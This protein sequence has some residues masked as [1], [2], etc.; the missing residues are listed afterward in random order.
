[1]RG[2]RVSEVEI[3]RAHEDGGLPG[4]PGESHRTGAR[5]VVVSGPGVDVGAL[6]IE[7]VV[8]APGHG[9]RR[10]GRRVD[11][12][13]VFVVAGLPPVSRVLGK[14]P[15]HQR[16]PFQGYSGQALGDDRPRRSPRY[17][18]YL[19]AEHL[20]YFQGLGGQLNVDREVGSVGGDGSD[21]PGYLRE[22]RSSRREAGRGGYSHEGGVIPEADVVV[23]RR[24]ARQGNHHRH[25]LLEDVRMRRV[26][27]RGAE[28]RGGAGGGK[29]DVG[30]RQQGQGGGGDGA[31]ADGLERGDALVDERLQLESF[32]AR[33]PV[34]IE[35]EVLRIGVN[36]R[37]YRL[38]DGRVGGAPLQGALGLHPHQ[39]VKID[40]QLGFRRRGGSQPRPKRPGVV[41]GEAVPHPHYPFAEVGRGKVV[42][43]G[44][45][46]GE[47]GQVSGQ[48]QLEGG[49]VLPGYLLYHRGVVHDQL[50][51]PGFSGAHPP[52]R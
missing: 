52:P 3:R 34:R 23:H 45:V 48:A 15:G 38:Y 46:V 17:L 20:G 32:R 1:M 12:K 41:L 25:G 35:A 8:G 2:F 27:T 18:V 40:T 33:R 30:H 50:D 14:Y 39:R 43:A 44:G 37:R 9:Y 10:G 29:V 28:R 47:G 49:D 19:E 13:R 11:V 5:G 21:G 4:A 36:P 51:E 24:G 16:P 31:N 6:R 42:L 7:P 26:V 22:I